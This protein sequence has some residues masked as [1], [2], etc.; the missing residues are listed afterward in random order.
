MRGAVG[1]LF[2]F[3]VL[4][5]AG[6]GGK[7]NTLAPASPQEHRISVLFWIMMV[8]AWIGFAVIAGLLTLGWVRRKHDGL[9]WGGGERAATWVVIGVGV[10]IPIVVL[11]ALFVYSNVFVLDSTAAPK[12]G[13]TQRTVQVT[14]HQWFWEINYVGT[15]AVTANELHIPVGGRIQIEGRTTD[16][17]HSFWVPELNRKIDLIPGRINRVLLQASRS[18]VYR[19]QCAEFCGLQHAHMAMSVYADPPARFRAWLANESRPGREPKTAQES[20]GREIFLSHTCSGCHTVRGTSAH[21]RIGP[22]LTHVGGRAT[23]GALTIP[24]TPAYMRN[25]IHDPQ[26]FKDGAKMPALHLTDD[27][28][29]SVVAYLESLK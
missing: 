23:L 11:S 26:H 12:P 18:G 15:E 1:V 21:S 25:W 14:G 9:P 13:T 19:G 8:G 20:R 29:D 4:V 17:I 7:Q 28:V 10:A 6:C 3:T 5:L 24:N 2:A 16:V 27:E 22:D